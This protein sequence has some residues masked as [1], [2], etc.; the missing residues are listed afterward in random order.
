MTDNHIPITNWTAED[1]PLASNV[2]YGPEGSIEEYWTKMSANYAELE[3]GSLDDQFADDIFD[4]FDKD[5]DD[6]SV[7]SGEDE[8]GNDDDEI[9]QT[10]LSFAQGMM[11]DDDDDEEGDQNYS[12]DDDGYDH[13]SGVDYEADNEEPI[14]GMLLS[15]MHPKHTPLQ[16]SELGL[17]ISQSSKNL[18][19]HRL[20]D[21]EMKQLAASY[22]V[23]RSE[24]D[25]GCSGEEEEDDDDDDEQVCAAGLLMGSEDDDEED[26]DAPQV[27]HSNKHVHQET[28]QPR[29][30]QKGHHRTIRA[31]LHKQPVAPQPSHPFLRQ[32]SKRDKKGDHVKSKKEI[33]RKHKVN[34]DVGTTLAFS[35]HFINNFGTTAVIIQMLLL[36]MVE[37]K[38]QEEE[39]LVLAVK[40]AEAKRKKFKE[41]GIYPYTA[42]LFVFLIM[43]NSCRF[44]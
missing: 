23:E 41:V 36:K 38:R 18:Q 14:G 27:H 17:P 7:S 33:E 10:L 1:S 4:V 32:Q 24:N 9:G 28:H 29:A 13:Q 8:N 34:R 2:S 5:N 15:D 19:P 26:L 42:S 20:S 31:H 35:I 30:Q 43:Q 40:K 22:K 44:C 3:N 21:S 12:D 6:N 37:K 25:D 11:Q 16:N 39:Q